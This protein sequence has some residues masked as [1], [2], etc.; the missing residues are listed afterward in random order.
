MTRSMTA[1][2]FA[3]LTLALPLPA[4]ELPSIGRKT[5]GMQKQSGY[6]TFYWDADEGKIWLQ[7]DRL[8]DEFL[9]LTSLATGMGSNPVGLDR[10][11]IGSAKIVYFERVGPKLLL[12]EPNQRYRAITTDAAEARAV[13]ESFAQSVIWAGGVAASSGKSVLVDATSLILRDAHYVIGRLKARDQGSFSLDKDRS[14]VYLPR[15]KAFPRNT[16]LEVTLTFASE[17]PGSLVR[18]TTPTP[19]SLTLRQHHSFVKLPDDGYSPRKFDPRSGYWAQTYADYAAPLDAPLQQRFISRHRLV[20]KNPAA[21]VSEAIKPIVYY[22][23]PGT[24]EPVRSALLDGARW[25]AKA[26]EEIGYRNAYRVE[27]LPVDADPLDVRY[28]VIQWV[29]RS[30]RGWSYGASITDP[31]TGEIIKGHVSLG[32]LRVRQDRLL[33][34]GLT[35]SFS[36]ANCG[37]QPVIEAAY[38][39]QL[40]PATDAVEIAL[41]RIRQLAAHEVGHTLG[42]AHNFIASTYGDR[43]SV[44]DYPAPLALLSGG[45]LDMSKAYGVGIGSWDAH[46]IRYGYSDFPAGSDEQTELEAIVREGLAA[47]LLFISD[48]DARPAGAAHPYANLWDNGSDPVTALEQIMAVRRYALDRFGVDNL[49]DGQPLALLETTL[50]PLYLHH[51]FQLGATAKMLGGVN[52]SYAVKGD[53]QLTTQP[54]AAAAQ[55][56]ALEALLKTLQPG[57]LD[58]PEALT[59]NLTPLPIGYNDRRERFRG[60]TAITFD[61]LGPAE[62][63]IRMTLEPLLQ[64]QRAARMEL[65][66]QLDSDSPGLIEV[67][68]RLLAATWGKSV[69]KEARLAAL[70]RLAQSMVVDGLMALATDAEAAVDVRAIAEQQLR[71]LAGQISKLRTHRRPQ[72]EAHRIHIRD[73]IARFQK[74]DYD[75]DDAQKPLPAPPGSPIGHRNR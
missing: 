42:L 62:V 5:S 3:L 9:Y 20:K 51:R 32:S 4:E 72:V 37:L 13:R 44:M 48:A 43:A 61:P 75:A 26:F 55:R 50:A 56:A 33:M 65:Q 23:D 35:P 22:L 27:M 53:G 54:I 38:L 73:R 21:E 10:G 63:A 30:T 17:E 16:E 34:E 28:N 46:A 60:R 15:S 7:I 68:D 59:K 69:P 49:H 74:R 11:Q 57:V 58:I 45:Q 6:F 66:H 14:A 64:R 41:A 25:W 40:D 18:E 1:F 47:G 71:L 52:Y 29:H 67:L 24:P 39:A 31:R 8:N 36:T 2:R 70:Q 12:I 19:G